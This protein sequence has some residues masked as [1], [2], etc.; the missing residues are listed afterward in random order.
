MTEI[1]KQEQ[2]RGLWFALGCYGVWGLFP[3]YW[4]PLNHSPIDAVQILAHRV[5]WSSVAAFAMLFYFKQSAAVY[6]V[7]RQPRLL[8]WFVCS[9]ALI[10]INWLVY[11]W[12]M[13]NNHVLDASLGYM[14]NPL[15][16][17]F[18]GSVVLGERLNS[19]QK[20]ALLAAA[21]GIAWLVLQV[22]QIPWVALALGLSFSL[23]GLVR[24]T[25]P[26]DALPGLALETLLLLPVAL[27]YLGWCVWQGRLVFGELN[28]LQL[29]VLLGS[30][31]AT[32]FPLLWFA[33]AA[34][35]ISLSLLGM[36]Q[37][38]TPIVQMLLGLFLF[39]E[40]FDLH[41]FIGFACVWVGAAVFL[42]GAWR[43]ARVA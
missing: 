38:G 5:L 20:T 4:Y 29:A 43:S 13:V 16:N 35:R 34:K 15:L 28:A 32:S 18:F 36:L 11:V 22:G 23:Y 14:I 3:L 6:T 21:A 19:T 8:F 37:Y 25:A 2:R 31:I 40:V 30:G 24:K 39:G 12:A 41:R 7:L 26:I 1:S 10:S 42:W 33:A 17:V 27:G 9:A